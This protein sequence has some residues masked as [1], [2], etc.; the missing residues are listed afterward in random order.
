MYMCIFRQYTTELVMHMQT[1][2]WAASFLSKVTNNGFLLWPGRRW[3]WSRGEWKC[4]ERLIIYTCSYDF[5]HMLDLLAVAMVFIWGQSL[6]YSILSISSFV[7]GQ[8]LFEEIRY[9][10]W[11]HLRKICKICTDQC[12]S[13]GYS[14][15]RPISCV[16]SEPPTQYMVVKRYHL[17]VYMYMYM[18]NVQCTCM[19]VVVY[20]ALSLWMSLHVCE[21][22]WQEMGV[23]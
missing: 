13:F 4:L 10:I 9:L 6:F 16:P 22:V 21:K 11:S 20:F 8:C 19:G 5:C 12:G 14:Q 17:Q 2:W 18:C 3:R 7:Q 15:A 23:V 1:S